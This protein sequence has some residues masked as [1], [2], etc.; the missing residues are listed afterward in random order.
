MGAPL[1][2]LPMRFA[3]LTE[4]PSIPLPAGYQ[5]REFSPGEEESLARC[6]AEA[7]GPGWDVARVTREITGAGF[8]LRTFV[9]VYDNEVVATASA[10]HEEKRFPG[11][12]YIH[13][14]AARPDHQG[15]KLG[16]IATVAAMRE[17]VKQ[18][19]TEA[20]LETDTFRVPA[21]VSYLRLGYLPTAVE[22]AHSNRWAEFFD[23]HPSLRP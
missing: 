19:F 5:V 9:V 10:A 6:M 14:V 12:G 7:E 13:W 3:D 21:I 11:V 20:V 18:G 1:S 16:S 22:E 2:Q 23:E 17:F 15:K 4:T 8:V